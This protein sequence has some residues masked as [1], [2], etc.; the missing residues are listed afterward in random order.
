MP[1]E[2]NINRYPDAQYA[3]VLESMYV[4]PEKRVNNERVL[5]TKKLLYSYQ[6]EDTSRNKRNSI[7]VYPDTMFG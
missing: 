2:W 6:W 7:A 4:T 5:D 1:L 3:E